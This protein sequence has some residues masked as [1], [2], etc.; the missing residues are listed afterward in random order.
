MFYPSYRHIAF[1]RRHRQMLGNFVIA[2]LGVL[3]LGSLGHALGDDAPPPYVFVA[4]PNYHPHC[5]EGYG[6]PE[7]VIAGQYRCTY[8]GGR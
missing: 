3:L 8:L 7:W 4:S 1:L 5:P 2:L 6:E